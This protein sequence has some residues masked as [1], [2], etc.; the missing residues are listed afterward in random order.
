MQLSKTREK[1]EKES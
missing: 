1:S